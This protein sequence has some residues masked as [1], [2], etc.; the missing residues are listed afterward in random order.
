MT[1]F[2]G[3]K[4]DTWLDG[5]IMNPNTA[6]WIEVGSLLREAQA[7]LA[8]DGPAANVSGEFEEFLEHNELELAWDTLAEIAEQAEV[9]SACWQKLAQAAW[10][11][12]IFSKA[13]E[14]ARRAV[15]VGIEK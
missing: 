12:Q 14:A 4:R 9:P 11:M 13:E 8:S 3:E 15:G 2:Y 1:Q 7:C 6:T 5:G 10:L